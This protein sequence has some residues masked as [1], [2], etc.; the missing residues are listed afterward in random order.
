MVARVNRDPG[1]AD[2]PS[3]PPGSLCEGSLADVVDWNGP[4]PRLRESESVRLCD[5]LTIP[6]QQPRH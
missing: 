2:Q 4:M 3:A 5:G 6:G 1:R